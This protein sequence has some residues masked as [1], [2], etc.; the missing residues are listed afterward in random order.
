MCQYHSIVHV[1]YEQQVEFVQLSLYTK[2]PDTVICGTPS[3][4]AF[5]VSYFDSEVKFQI[6]SNKH[7]KVF[8]ALVYKKHAIALKSI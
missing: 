1:I 8:R 7:N 6:Q 3:R 2:Y 5:P 4:L